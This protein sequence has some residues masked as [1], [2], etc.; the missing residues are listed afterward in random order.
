MGS[1]I[2]SVQ[3]TEAGS[4]PGAKRMVS[5]PLT[6]L[7][8]RLEMA[9]KAQVAFTPEIQA[10]VLKAAAKLLT[11]GAPHSRIE[12]WK[13]TSLREFAAGETS[14]VTDSN[15]IGLNAGVA[16]LDSL[17]QLSARLVFSNGVMDAGQSALEGLPRGVSISPLSSVLA[18]AKHPSYAAVLEQ[19]GQNG[20]LEHHDSFIA[21]LALALLQD[22]VVINCEEDCSESSTIEIVWNGKGSVE[23]TQ[24]PLISTARV[25]I[26]SNSKVPCT[27]LER[28]EGTDTYC[29]VSSSSIVAAES[30]VVTHA[31]IQT[32]SA[33][34]THFSATHA[35]LA[36]ESVV[37]TVCVNAGG[38]LVRNEVYNEINGRAVNALLSGVS[39]ASGN[40]LVDNYTVIDHALPESQS[41]ER[42]KGIYAGK[43]KGI[44]NGTIIVRQDAQQTNAIQS[45]NSLLLSDDAAS[46]SRP[47]LKIWA[48]D[49][50]CTHGATVGQMDEQALFYLRARGVPLEQAKVLLMHAFTSE[51]FED[52]VDVE[53]KHYLEQV[54]FSKL[55]AITR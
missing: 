6:W 26:F 8:S 51:A 43:A 54:V 34:A 24:L 2:S 14:A 3:S 20:Q 4:I 52:V 12:A 36:D 19:L 29:T 17:P 11:E 7:E 39:V 41:T 31:R 40:E 13:Y 22:G 35:K 49:V 47:Q 21:N 27:V 23:K 25:F 18:D 44:F 9:R 37:H 33:T 16:A 55:D 28:F 46:F 50:K 32:E 1:P 42:Y 30:A 5:F 48:D 15:S 38:Q 10:L 53:L 45:N